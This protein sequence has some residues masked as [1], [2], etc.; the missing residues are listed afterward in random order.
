MDRS[1]CFSFEKSAARTHSQLLEDETA[2]YKKPKLSPLSKAQEAPAM[3][4]KSPSIKAERTAEKE[5]ITSTSAL[6]SILVS[7][8]GAEAGASRSFFGLSES[9]FKIRSS[10][11]FSSL[12][13]LASAPKTTGSVFKFTPLKETAV[14]DQ[15]TSSWFSSMRPSRQETNTANN[16]SLFTSLPKT[17]TADRS[18]FGKTSETNPSKDKET[19]NQPDGFHTVKTAGASN[20]NTHQDQVRSQKHVSEVASMRCE[21]RNVFGLPSGIHSLGPSPDKPGSKMESKLSTD[22]SVQKSSLTAQLRASNYQ[23]SPNLFS[24]MTAGLLEPNNIAGN[25]VTIEPTVNGMA[26]EIY[27]PASIFT[28]QSNQSV[29][30]DQE[31]PGRTNPSELMSAKHANP[32]QPKNTPNASIFGQTITVASKPAHPASKLKTKSSLFSSTGNIQGERYG[33]MQLHHTSKDKASG[34]D[35]QLRTTPLVSLTVKETAEA[36]AKFPMFPQYAFLG[37]RVPETSSSNEENSTSSTVHGMF[38]STTSVDEEPEPVLLN[39]NSPW[40]AFI[41]GSQGSGKSY[42]LSA[43]IENCLYASPVIGRLPKPLAGV[44]FHNNTAS[45]HNVCEAAQLVSLGVKVNVLVSR[46]NY[47]ALS[48]IYKNAVGS[49]YEKL[50]NVQPLVLQSHHITAERM[51]R[52]MAFAESETAVPLYM[53]VIM[54]ILR[55]MAITG[56]PFSYATFKA[57]LEKE[58]LQPGQKVMMA[59]R[60]NLLES[61]LDPS[62]IEA[63]KKSHSKKS[64]LLST[65][66]GTLTIVDLSDPFLDAGTTCTLFDILLSVFLSSRPDSGLLVCLDEAHKFMKNTPAAETFTENLLTVIREQRHNAC[67]IVIATQEPTIS[68][69][70]LDLC[71]MTFVHRFTSPDWMVTLKNH[72]AGASDLATAATATD[73]NNDGGGVG[74]RQGPAALF[75]KI[76]NLDVGESLLFAPSAVLEV[77]EQGQKKKLGV[78]C[79]RFKTRSRLGVDGGQSVLAVR[80]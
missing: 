10:S 4:G 19:N 24:N 72:L 22:Q 42:T 11:L 2:I 59:M 44:V 49:K 50:L 52:L 60:L 61:F 17:T 45:A 73:T 1:K 30:H 80:E 3:V 31:S 12:P 9:D 43:I 71:S 35:E 26:K 25:K 65:S 13:S 5:S 48:A 28:Q 78:G 37:C 38:S 29:R 47:H 57:N 74:Q 33:F 32:L 56:I 75:G 79:V 54:R 39:T 16:T 70:L 76:I 34:A 20:N 40:S 51:H 67:R 8:I 15:T 18:T 27:K 77:D 41:C 58:G 14:G 21:H 66:P 63:S 36:N 64:D 23:G 55:D 68:P 6:R 46:S 7:G 62:C 69:K 53:E